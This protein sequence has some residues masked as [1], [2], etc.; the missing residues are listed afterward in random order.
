MPAKNT[1]LLERVQNVVVEQLGCDEG[2]VTAN[3]D[4]REAPMSADSLDHVEII[5]ALEEHFDVI[6]PDEDAEKLFTAAKM[7]DYIEKLKAHK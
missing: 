5:M 2:E 6:I 7:A 3:A 1:T 4:I